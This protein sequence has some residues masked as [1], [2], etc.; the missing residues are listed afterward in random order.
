M[1]VFPICPS[2]RQHGFAAAEFALA[3][4]PLLFCALSALEAARWHMT[5][6]MLNLALLE[7]AR[8][9]A[10][11]H[12]RRD[13]MEHAFER[14]LLPLFEPAGGHGSAYARMQAAFRDIGRETGLRAW[15][16]DV[17]SPPATAY[18][19]FGDTGLRVPGAAGLPAIGNDYQAE[20]HARRRRMGWREGR[21][22]SSGMTIFEANTLSLRLTYLHPP[23]VPGIRSLLGG[24]AAMRNSRDAGS[25]AGMLTI[26]MVIDIP[27]QSHPVHWAADGQPGSSAPRLPPVIGR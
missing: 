14:A 15:R 3:A 4:L 25:L 21:G 6:Q 24:I 1:P 18:A 12:G 10:V 5:R 9:G 2:R 22:P 8:A 19:D 11:A 27:M 16:I 23:M 20:Q 13:A 17:L 7:A 26:R